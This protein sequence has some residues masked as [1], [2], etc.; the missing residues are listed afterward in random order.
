MESRFEDSLSQ[1]QNFFDRHAA[2]WDSGHTEEAGRL[3]ELVAALGLKPGS[4]V[5]EPGCGTGVISALL[6]EAL[7]ERGRLYGLDISRLMIEQAEAKGLG[8]GAL[9]HHADA[10]RLP[11]GNGFAD[12]VVCFRV[13]PHLDNKAE[14]LAEF[15]R[16][17]KPGGLLAVA[18]PAGREALNAY[19]AAAWDEVATDMLPD[20]GGMRD[21]LAKA[22][23]EIT[24]L[25]DSRQR[26]LL[27]ARK[28]RAA[29]RGVAC[30]NGLK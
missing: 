3:R 26:Y 17:L 21:F 12:A 13:F 23:F 6:L 29:G 27:L 24:R 28:T 16:V 20:E 10:A 30:R 18:H 22:G 7:G 4:T 9:F 25:E 5:L 1:K 2:G 11:F 8:P 19:H 15:S 14:A